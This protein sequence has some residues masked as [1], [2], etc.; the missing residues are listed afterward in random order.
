M[1]LTLAM[2]AKAIRE[3]V[4]RCLHKTAV[5]AY[6]KPEESNKWQSKSNAAGA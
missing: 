2:F 1:W 4:K 6:I 3:E 5:Y